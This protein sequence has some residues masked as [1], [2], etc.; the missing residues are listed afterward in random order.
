MRERDIFEELEQAYQNAVNN[1]DAETIQAILNNPVVESLK[2]SPEYYIRGLKLRASAFSLFGELD[3]A[4]YEYGLAYDF[5]DEEEDRAKFLLDWSTLFL[6]E[7]SI[8]RGEEARIIA[9]SNGVELLEKASWELPEEDTYGQLTLACLK[10]FMLAQK[11]E[12]EEALAT[13]EDL[14]FEPVPIPRVNDEE[15]MKEFFSHIH[16]GMAVAIEA[17]DV[18]LLIKFI[19]CI[20]IDDE[21]LTHDQ[22]LFKLYNTTI[23]FL[24]EL[25]TEFTEEFN[26]LFRLKDK[27]RDGM[28]NYAHFMELIGTQD[29]D[30]LTLFFASFHK[31]E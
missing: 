1:Q 21:S 23:G 13:F 18:Q 17:K 7:L 16:K 26:T 29:F 2:P 11:G 22:T 3:K 4:S 10:A 9:M 5:L 27:L 12:L 25:R 19:R 15:D 8:G 24:F 28:P 6:A 20:S 14:S 30:A 31:G